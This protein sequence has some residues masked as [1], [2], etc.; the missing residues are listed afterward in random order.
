MSKIILFR[1]HDN[2]EVCKDHLRIFRSFNPDIPVYGLYGGDAAQFDL[3]NNELKELS[4][5]YCLQYL[6]AEAKW[7]CFDYALKEWYQH[8]GKF[9][10]FSQLYL[11]EW[12]FIFLENIDTLYSEIPEGIVGFSGLT[13]LSKI[14]KEW[15][16]T[17]NEVKRPEWLTLL[18]YVKDIYNYSSQPVGILCPGLS[19]PRRFLDGFLDIDLPNLGNDELRFPLYAQLLGLQLA[20]TN[21][22]RK[23]F[24][25][26]EWRFFNC[27]NFEISQSVINRQFSKRRGRRAFHPVRVVM[28]PKKIPHIINK[29]NEENGN[30]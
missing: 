19:L 14:E 27:N 11:L 25:K 1:Y 22:Y 17:N 30:N 23:W 16:W 3:F 4:G 6:D 26:R 18:Q 28:D 2:L 24:S 13:P 21:F 5:N 8:A 10:D 29:M 20:D 15:Y 9:I 12:D 7:K